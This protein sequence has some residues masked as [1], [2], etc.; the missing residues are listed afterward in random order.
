MPPDDFAPTP[1]A[2]FGGISPRRAVTKPMLANRKKNR[3][4]REHGVV[5]PSLYAA[6]D[7]AI[8]P[9]AVRLAVRLPECRARLLRERPHPVAR[10]WRHPPLHGVRPQC[11]HG[12]Q[13]P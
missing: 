3:G 10:S 8:Q 1:L 5:S 2:A 13:P 6:G 4:L 7:G 9:H 11:R 12:L